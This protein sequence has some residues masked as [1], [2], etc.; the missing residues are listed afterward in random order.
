M[1]TPCPDCEK[2]NSMFHW[3]A[4]ACSIECG[5]EYFK[6]IEESR[7]PKQPDIKHENDL[8]NTVLRNKRSYKKKNIEEREQIE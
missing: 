6:R 3:R 8:N 2:D 1:Y 5:R 7:R 4:V